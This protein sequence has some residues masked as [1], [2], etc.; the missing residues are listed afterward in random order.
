MK[1][2]LMRIKLLNL[3]WPLKRNQKSQYLMQHQMPQL[4]PLL[5]QQLMLHL[6]NKFQKSLWIRIKLWLMWWSQ[7]FT[8][9]KEWFLEVY[10]FWEARLLNWRNIKKRLSVKLKSIKNGKLSWWMNAKLWILWD[11][12]VQ[13]KVPWNWTRISLLKRFKIP[14]QNM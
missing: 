7:P 2:R 4:M 5:T 8:T 11:L 10:N 12:D 6:R 1:A 14:I 3:T 9:L 13:L